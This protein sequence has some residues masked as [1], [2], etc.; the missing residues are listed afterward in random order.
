MSDDSGLYASIREAAAKTMVDSAFRSLRWEGVQEF[1][2]EQY[3]RVADVVL[4]AAGVPAL[5]EQ[6][7]ARDRRIN[8]LTD[9]LTE[10]VNQCAPEPG[11]HFCAAPGEVAYDNA[12]EALAAGGD[13]ER[14]E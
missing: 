2:R 4:D 12:V 13:T 5:L 10:L 11:D 1:R 7:E 14:D 8:E 3:R 6:V 9:A